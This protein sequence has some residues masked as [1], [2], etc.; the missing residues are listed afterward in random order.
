MTLQS[1]AGGWRTALLSMPV[2]E[3]RD[4]PHPLRVIPHSMSELPYRMRNLLG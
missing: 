1:S 4:N 3:P 2:G